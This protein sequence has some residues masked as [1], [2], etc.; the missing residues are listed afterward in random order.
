[1][2]A[3]ACSEQKDP[4][5]ADQEQRGRGPELPREHR[6]SEPNESR[7]RLT[8]TALSVHETVAGTRSDSRFSMAGAAAK[9]ERRER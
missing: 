9:E 3:V 5:Q 7:L 8:R 2:T 4:A 6:L 1:V